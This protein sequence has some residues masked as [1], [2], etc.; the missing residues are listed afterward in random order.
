MTEQVNIADAEG[1]TALHCAANVGSVTV[2]KQL[3][4]AKANPNVHEKVE[5]NNPLMLAAK[6][7]ICSNIGS[8][9]N[10]ARIFQCLSFIDRSKRGYE[11]AE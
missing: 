10:A 7:R 8:Y 1:E 5:G 9:C 3:L 6:V 4:H 11:Q 2:V